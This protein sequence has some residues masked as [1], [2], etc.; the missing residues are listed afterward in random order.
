MMKF[1]SLALLLVVASIFTSVSAE[2]IDGPLLLV[3]KSFDYNAEIVVGGNLTV[4]VELFN[5]GDGAAYDISVDDTQDW[6]GWNV[7]DGSLKQTIPKI[8]AGEKHTYSV[9]VSATNTNALRPVRAIVTYTEESGGDTITTHST[10][11]PSRTIFG[12]STKGKKIFENYIEIGLF[13]ALALF[14]SGPSV[15]SSYVYNN[16]YTNGIPKSKLQK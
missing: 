7:I 9:V 3:H 13:L 6:I 15:F 2:Q 14:A 8:S 4:S 11:I 12:R 5:I 16:H 1:I 10:V